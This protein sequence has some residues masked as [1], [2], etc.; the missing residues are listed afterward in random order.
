MLAAHYALS[1]P[2]TCRLLRAYTN[3][4]YEV[5]AGQERFVLKVY[6]GNWRT[7]AKIRFEIALLCHLAWRGLQVARP[8]TG[9]D[10]D[11]VRQIETDTGNRYAVLYEYAEG[12]KP[13]QPLTLSLYEAFGR[14]IARMHSLS[15]DFVTDYSRPNIDLDYLVDAPLALVLP[16]VASSEEKESLQK[17]AT[18]I[19]NTL[20]EIGLS[21]LDWGVVHGDA[22]LD[23]LHITKSGEIVLY[24]FDSGGLG[25]RASDI[26]GWAIKNDLYEEKGAAFRRG[27]LQVRPLHD[28]EVSAAPY[29]AMAWEI[30][31]LRVDLEQRVLKQGTASTQSYLSEQ[32]A[33]LSERQQSLE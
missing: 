15:D 31:G 10:Q 30:W 4:V 5:M 18:Q 1:Q 6:G 14:A 29:L 22:T 9:H 20:A 13:Q 11:F 19:K 27:Y 3:D 12:E 24:D 23:N 7:E 21:S 32:I 26:Q 8:I 28:R 16:L 33:R 25:W 17:S 2:I